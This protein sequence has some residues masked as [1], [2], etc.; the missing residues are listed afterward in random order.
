V[1]EAGRLRLFVAVDVPDDVRSRLADALRG[2]HERV[3]GARWTR[4][5]SWHVTLKFLGW[6]RS[7]L[8][9]SVRE[10][11]ARA[12]PGEAFETSLTAAGAFPSPRRARVLWVGLDDPGGRFG[13]MVRLLDECLL[14]WFE[15]ERRAF[16]PHLTL[17]RLNPPQDLGTAAGGLLGT[18]VRSDRFVVDELVL[19]RSH[20]SPKGARYEALARLPLRD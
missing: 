10:A 11:V 18:P 6:T 4:P 5:E 1:A 8:V 2:C 7:D 3:P 17:A 14:P 16:T 20:L 12:A 9:E 15:P 19:Y 13:Q